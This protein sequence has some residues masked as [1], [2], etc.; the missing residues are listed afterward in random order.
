MLHR[1]KH[2][3]E[4]ERHEHEHAKKMKECA[5]EVEHLKQAFDQGLQK[6]R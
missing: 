3:W 2:A 5:R 4:D 6:T 1:K